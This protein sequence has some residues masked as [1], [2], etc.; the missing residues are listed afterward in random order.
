MAVWQPRCKAE[1]TGQ[2]L[3][4]SH[5]QQGSH[6]Q[7]LI[8]Q[9]FL[10]PFSLQLLLCSTRHSHSCYKLPTSQQ[11]VGNKGSECSVHVGV[12]ATLPC[13]LTC[14]SSSTAICVPGQGSLGKLRQTFYLGTR[15]GRS[16]L[17]EAKAIPANG[18]KGSFLKQRSSQR[19]PQVRAGSGVT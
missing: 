11:Q 16:L 19:E 2:I 13:P 3:Q 17:T 12:F 1:W 18:L 8:R 14:H 5:L 10:Q 6:A 4:P 15:E 9:S 7:R